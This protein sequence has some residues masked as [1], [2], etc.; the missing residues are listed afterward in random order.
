MRMIFDATTKPFPWQPI[1][2]S[3]GAFL[4]GCVL[5]LLK[6]LR[7]RAISGIWG[8]FMIT[9]ALVS[10]AYYSTDWYILHRRGVRALTSGHHEVLEGAV[11]EFHPMPDD[12][13]SNESFTISGHT[14]SYSDHDIFETT[15][16]F[17]QTAPHGGPIHAGMRLRVEFS[18]QCILRIEGLPPNRSAARLRPD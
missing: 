10:A 1:W 15:V 11:E 12:G 18:D 13:S 14:F 2:S 16:C 3:S 17:N 8:Y 6:R 5:I 4:F 9:V 7:W